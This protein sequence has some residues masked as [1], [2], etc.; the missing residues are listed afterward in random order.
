[1]EGST[2]GLTDEEISDINSRLSQMSALIEERQA[3][4]NEV[5]R[6]ELEALGISK[7]LV[8]TYGFRV[9]PLGH[10]PSREVLSVNGS[11]HLDEVLKP[12]A[13]DPL[14]TLAYNCLSRAVRWMLQEETDQRYN[15]DYR[16]TLQDVSRIGATN[17]IRGFG[18]SCFAHAQQILQPYGVD[19]CW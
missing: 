12:R 1:M 9:L 11:M 2:K 5:A 8:S 18:K 7:G 14:A 13:G 15:N 3:H 10:F 6:L 4:L 19:L 16:P 17:S